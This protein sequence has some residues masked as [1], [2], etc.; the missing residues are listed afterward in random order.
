MVINIGDQFIRARDNNGCY[1]VMP[2]H[3]DIIKACV[4]LGFIFLGNIIWQKITTTKTTGGCVWMGSIYFPRDGYI[5]YEHEYIMIFKKRGKA[6][7]PDAEMKELSKLHKEY[8]SKWFRGIWNDIQPVRQNKHEAMFPLE[9]PARIIQMFSFAGETVLDPF[10]GSGTTIEAA[11]KWKRNSIGIELN[12]GYI[13]DICGRVPNVKIVTKDTL[14]K[15]V[16]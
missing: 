8:R 3:T 14:L 10:V 12:S 4:E 5:T 11:K 7:K 15:K 2:I 6:P 1:E 16:G 9:L 13:S